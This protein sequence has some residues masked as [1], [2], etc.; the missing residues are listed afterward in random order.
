M[1]TFN[2][3]NDTFIRGFIDKESITELVT[4]EEI[5]KLVFGFC[6]QE[7][8]YVTSPIRK[9]NTPG[10]WFE[11][12]NN[13]VL[14]FIDWGCYKKPQDCYNLV[15]E[16]FKIPNFYLTLQFI[17][18]KLIAG[19]N[20]HPATNKIKREEC[21]IVKKK[22]K[23][24]IEARDFNLEDQ[25]YWSKYGIRKQNLIEDN[26][27][28]VERYYVL[29]SKKGD[30]TALCSEIAYSYN[31]FP[32]KRKKI[33]FP[34]RKGKNRFLST[35]TKDDIGGINSLVL[36]GEKLIITKSYKDYRVLKN[37]G[38]NVVWF[39]NEGMIPEKKYLVDLLSRFKKVILWYDNDRAGIQAST[40]ISSYMNSLSRPKSFPLYLPESL[41]SLGIKDPSDCCYKDYTFFKK[42]VNDFL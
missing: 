7:F 31:D 24:L 30:H 33:Y 18:D 4:Q 9:D 1:D 10:C 13:G 32:E 29:G 3:Q 15:Q 11:R 37:E 16:Y 20:I 38:K 36:Y 41:L 12:H 28:P 27:F 23:I 25:I 42:F 19:K 14:Y 26:V 2:Y 40:E 8:Q 34:L 22:V 6:P 17:Y 39:Q 35:C 21:N 5:F